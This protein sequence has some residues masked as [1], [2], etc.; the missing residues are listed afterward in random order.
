MT[1]EQAIPFLRKLNPN[2][3][4]LSIQDLLKDKIKMK[5][6]YIIGNPPYNKGLW[7]KILLKLY[8]SLKENGTMDMIHPATPFFSQNEKKDKNTTRYIEMLKTNKIEVEE[9]DPLV[10]DGADIPNNIVRVTMKKEKSNV[11]VEKFTYINKNSYTNITMESINKQGIDPEKY[12]SYKNEY[13]T[14]VN[15]YGSL[16]QLYQKEIYYEDE[17]EVFEL[18]KV[19]GHIIGSKEK[20]DFLS[21]F[22]QDIFY[23]PKYP[24]PHGFIVNSEKE[25]ENVARYLETKFAR[26]AIR[27]YKQTFNVY[28]YMFKLIPLIP[29]DLDS[30]EYTDE[31]LF[32]RFNISDNLREEILKL[33]DYTCFTS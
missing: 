4:Y 21:V 31:A 22:S 32:E 33:E 2:V 17:N 14:L 18:S 8:S 13:K 19:R 26:F 5:F 27:F 1:N 20:A 12:I 3:E 10:F 25:K 24:V 29:L 11:E 23:N 9:I 30:D 6:D 7:I 16:K 15:K 28:S